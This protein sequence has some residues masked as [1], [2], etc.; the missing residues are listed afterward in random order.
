M[1]IEANTYEELHICNVNEK[2]AQ[3]CGAESLFL[4][5]KLCIYLNFSMPMLTPKL[6]PTS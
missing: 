6:T 5:L 3:L 2:T 1:S 4:F